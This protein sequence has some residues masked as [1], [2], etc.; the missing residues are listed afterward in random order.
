MW[1]QVQ[2]N[3]MGFQQV[4][5]NKNF[6]VVDNSGGL[7]DPERGQSFDEIYKDIRSWVNT[8][9]RN[10]QANAWLANQQQDRAKSDK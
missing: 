5:G 6:Y 8:P 4:F 3:I 1:A 7:E 2:D 9:T 10:R